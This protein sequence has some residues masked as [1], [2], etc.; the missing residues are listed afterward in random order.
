MDIF[1]AATS[2]TLGNGHKTPFSHAPWLEG[3]KPID[4]TSHIFAKSNRKNWKIKYA[5]K[6]DVWINKVDL[7]ADFSMEHLTQFLNLW[8]LLQD[9]GL[10]EDVEDLI[11]WNLTENGQ[12]S[13]KRLLTCNSWAL[14]SFRCKNLLGRLGLPQSTK[15]LLGPRFKIGF[16]R[17]NAWRKEDGIMVGL[18]LYVRKLQNQCTTSSLTADTSIIFGKEL[19]IGLASP[20][21]NQHNDKVLQ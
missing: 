2:I 19:R 3:K 4:I 10:I 16:E 7:G 13:A 8:C 17:R 20:S 18:A 11:V 5:L 14:P 1:Y 9:V 15:D 12:Y 21:S 6:D